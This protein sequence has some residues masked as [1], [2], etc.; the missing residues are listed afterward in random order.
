MMR[1]RLLIISTIFPQASITKPTCIYIFAI[2]VYLCMHT[3]VM[4]KCRVKQKQKQIILGCNY[5]TK[6][7]WKNGNKSNK[8]CIT[9]TTNFKKQNK[10]STVTK[11]HL[12][13]RLSGGKIS[14]DVLQTYRHCS[15]PSWTTGT[16]QLPGWVITQLLRLLS[17]FPCCW[18]PQ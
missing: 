17:I 4:G 13:E 18:C 11:Q 14:T 12:H 7:K 9:I 8:A 5:K 15:T 16:W 10:T 2:Y 1:N 3:Q 6:M